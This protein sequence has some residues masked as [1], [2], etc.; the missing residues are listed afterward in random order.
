MPETKYANRGNIN[1][2][3]QVIGEGPER[4]EREANLPVLF[5]SIENLSGDIIMPFY[6]SSL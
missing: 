4:G 6:R 5:A 3:Y 2:A 1:I